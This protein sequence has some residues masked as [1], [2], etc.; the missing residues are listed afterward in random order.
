MPTFNRYNRHPL[1]VRVVSFVLIIAFVFQDVVW[2]APDLSPKRSPHSSTLAPELFTK[3]EGSGARAYLK[4]VESIIEEGSIPRNLLSLAAVKAA[5]LKHRNEPWFLANVSFTESPGQILV[6]VSSGYALRYFDPTALTVDEAEKYEAQAERRAGMAASEPLGKRLRKQLLNVKLLPPGSRPAMQRIK[7]TVVASE[8]LAAVS[9]RRVASAIRKLQRAKRGNLNLVLTRGNTMIA[10]LRELARKKGIDWSRVNILQLVEYEDMPPLS[11]FSFRSFL[12]EYFLDHL[13]ADNRVKGVNIYNIATM[14]PETYASE[15]RSRL[16]PDI[17]VIGLGLNDHIGFNEPGSPFDSVTRRV[18]LTE[19]TVRS[20]ISDN[21]VLAI[22]LQSHR[23]PRAYTMGMAEIASAGRIF[24]LASGGRKRAAV[25]QALRG[26]VTT[27]VP[28]SMLQTVASRT[29]VILDEEA[30]SGLENVDGVDGRRRSPDRIAGLEELFAAAGFRIDMDARSKTAFLK[31][32]AGRYLDEVADID[33]LAGILAGFNARDKAIAAGQE[34]RFERVLQNRILDYFLNHLVEEIRKV[35]PNSTQDGRH[36]KETFGLFR[37]FSRIF[38]MPYIR[39]RTE[40]RKELLTLFLLMHIRPEGS[41]VGSSVRSDVATE[42]MLEEIFLNR[43]PE[44]SEF[45]IEAVIALCAEEGRLGEYFRENLYPLLRSSEGLPRFAMGLINAFIN[46]E[47]ESAHMPHI[48]DKDRFFTAAAQILKDLVSDDLKSGQ[49]YFTRKL[50][51]YSYALIANSASSRLP[52]TCALAREAEEMLIEQRSRESETRYG[53]S[54][55]RALG[56]AHFVWE[57]TVDPLQRLGARPG[58]IAFLGGF[59]ELLYSGLLVSGLSVVLSGSF[60]ISPV[61]G[62]IAGTALSYFAFRDQHLYE[63][64]YYDAAEGML[65]TR[66]ATNDDIR[67]IALLNIT[68]RSL[69][70]VPLL[71]SAG[72]GV[73]VVALAAVTLYHALWNLAQMRHGKAMALEAGRLDDRTIDEITPIRGSPYA[74]G[75]TDYAELLKPALGQGGFE[76]LLKSSGVYVDAGCG[77]GRAPVEAALRYKKIRAYGVDIEEYDG[78]R[79]AAA[80]DNP[81][82]WLL[83]AV[84]RQTAR[85]SRRY[86]FIKSNISNVEL[87]ERPDLITSFFVFEKVVDP[88]GSFKNLYDQLAPG[89]TMLFTVVRPKG[90]AGTAYETVAADLL[91]ASGD[92]EVSMIPLPWRGAGNVE[93]KLVRIDKITDRQF[94]PHLVLKDSVRQEVSAG[95]HIFYVTSPSYGEPGPTDMAASAGKKL[96][97]EDPLT[98]VILHDLKNKFQIMAYCDIIM[99]NAEGLQGA[100]INEDLAPVQAWVDLAEQ[101]QVATLA[102]L[103]GEGTLDDTIATLQD[104]FTGLTLYTQQIRDRLETGGYSWNPHA[105][106]GAQIITSQST[107]NL[108]PLLQSAASWL[109]RAMN[110]VD[111][112]AVI[113]ES[114]A[115][116]RHMECAP[117]DLIIEIGVTDD[118][119]RAKGLFTYKMI[120]RMAVEELLRNALKY[121][122]SSK[123]SVNASLVG[124]GEIRVEVVD[125]GAGM[126]V[127]AR[128]KLFSPGY[129]TASDSRKGSGYGLSSLRSAIESVGG[130]IAVESELGKGSTFAFRLPVN[131]PLDVVERPR[132]TSPVIVAVSGLKGSGRRVMSQWL[133][134]KLGLRYVNVGFLVRVVMHEMLKARREGRR[135]DL[136]DEHAVVDFIREFLSSGRIDCTGPAITLDGLDT[137]EPD[138]ADGLAIR[139]RIKAEI[140]MDEENTQAMHGVFVFPGAKQALN[141]YLGSVARTIKDGGQYNGIV[142]RVTDPVPMKGIINIM[143]DAPVGVRALRSKVEVDAIESLD[144]FTGKQDLAKL[145]PDIHPIDTTVITRRT[146]E[147]AL[148]TVIWKLPSSEDREAWLAHLAKADTVVVYKTE[149]VSAVDFLKN[150]NYREV[151][152]QRVILRGAG[153]ERVFSLLGS[154]GQSSHLNLA[155]DEMSGDLYSIK[156]L[157]SEEDEDR[158]SSI[159]NVMDMTAGHEGI[160]QARIMS[161]GAN[162]WSGLEDAQAVVYPYVRGPDLQHYLGRFKTTP[163]PAY[164][165]ELFDI[166]LKVMDI[167]VFL[168]EKGVPGVWDINSGNIIITPEGRPVLIDYTEMKT[169]PVASAEFLLYESFDGARRTDIGVDGILPT[170]QFAADPAANQAIVERLTGIHRMVKDRRFTSIRQ[171]RDELMAV[172]QMIGSAAASSKAAVVMTGGGPTDMTLTSRHEITPDS[173]QRG[174]TTNPFILTHID[175]GRAFD[176][177]EWAGKVTR[178]RRDAAQPRAPPPEPDFVSNGVFAKMR[179]ARDRGLMARLVSKPNFDNL[180]ASEKEQLIEIA[181]RVPISVILG[182]A[183][184]GSRREGKEDPEDVYAHIRVAKET[185]AHGLGPTIWLGERLLEMMPREKLAQMLVEESQHLLKKP[186][187]LPSGRWINQDGKIDRRR[188]E[189]PLSEANRNVIE[190]DQSLVDYLMTLSAVAA[191]EPLTDT[192][193][194]ERH[195]PASADSSLRMEQ[196]HAPHEELLGFDVGAG[197]FIVPDSLFEA[198][199][200]A[201]LFPPADSVYHATKAERPFTVHQYDLML[202]LLNRIDPGLHMRLARLPDGGFARFNSVF[203]TPGHTIIP[204]GEALEAERLYAILRHER[205]SFLIDAMSSDKRRSLKTLYEKIS[206]DRDL[207]LTICGIL[208]GQDPVSE[209]LLVHDEEAWVKF[210][211]WITYPLFHDPV[212]NARVRRFAGQIISASLHSR[213]MASEVETARQ[214]IIALQNQAEK[215]AAIRF[216][217]ASDALSA[218]RADRPTNMAADRTR[219]DSVDTETDQGDH[220]LPKQGSAIRRVLFI[221]YHSRSNGKYEQDILSVFPGAA[222]LGVKTPGEALQ[223]LRRYGNSIGLVVTNLHFTTVDEFHEMGEGAQREFSAM[224]VLDEMARLRLSCPVV[225][226]TYSR[227]LSVLFWRWRLWQEYRKALSVSVIRRPTQ[228][229]FRRA[230]EAARASGARRGTG[231]GALQSGPTDM[232]SSPEKPSAVA[233]PRSRIREDARMR[234][235]YKDYFEFVFESNLKLFVMLGERMKAK[236]LGDLAAQEKAKADVTEYLV[237]LHTALT[238]FEER[239]KGFPQD[240]AMAAIHRF[241]VSKI[242]MA[243]EFINKNNEPAALATIA[244]VINAVSKA[245]QEA[246]KRSFDGLRRSVKVYEKDHKIVMWRHGYV[247]T[248]D[249][250]KTLLPQYIK[251]VFD[252]R[253]QAGRSLDEQEDGNADER[254]TITDLIAELMRDAA[255]AGRSPEALT[256]ASVDRALEALSGRRDVEEKR[257][258]RIVLTTCKALIEMGETKSLRYLLPLAA[259]YLALRIDHIG[260]ILENLKTG[261]VEPFRRIVSKKNER[262]I[263]RVAAIQDDLNKRKFTDALK[264]SHILRSI[265]QPYL[266]EP[267]LADLLSMVWPAINAVKEL[268]DGKI[269]AADTKKANFWLRLIRTKL[270]HSQLAGEFMVQFRGEYMRRRLTGQA[271]FL[272]QDTFVDVFE[273]FVKAKQLIRGSPE[274]PAVFASPQE[275][276]AF[277]IL[278][279]L[280]AFIPIDIEN[281]EKHSERIPNPLFK[282]VDTLRLLVE[283]DDIARILTIK[284][285]RDLTETLTA[286]AAMKERGAIRRLDQKERT[287]LI[288]AIAKDYGLDEPQ[289]FELARA[290]SITRDH[291]HMAYIDRAGQ[292]PTDMAF[293]DPAGSREPFVC[294]QCGANVT[295]LQGGFRDHCPVCLHSLHLD[296]DPGDRASGCGAIMEPVALEQN[297]K[298]GWVITYRCTA[299]GRERKNKAAPDDSMDAL[300]LISDP[301]RAIG[302]RPTDMAGRGTGRGVLGPE[303]DLGRARWLYGKRVALPVS[304]SEEHDA[305]VDWLKR[306]QRE[307][308]VKKDT[309]I[310]NFDTH[311]DAIEELFEELNPGSWMRWLK[312]QGMSTGRRVWV[313]SGAQAPYDRSTREEERYAY[314]KNIYSS[315][316]AM[317]KQVSGPAIVTIDYDYIAPEHGGEITPKAIKEKVRRIVAALFEKGIRPVAIHFAYSEE[318]LFEPAPTGLGIPRDPTRQVI[319]GAVYE[320]FGE[321][322]YLF[323]AVRRESGSKPTDMSSSSARSGEQVPPKIDTAALERDGY[324]A[325]IEHLYGLI[326]L[327]GLDAY[328]RSVYLQDDVGIRTR[329]DEL[330]GATRELMANRMHAGR[331]EGVEMKLFSKLTRD[332]SGNYGLDIVVVDNGKGL[333]IDPVVAVEGENATTDEGYGSRGLPFVR[334]VIMGGGNGRIEIETR[335]RRYAWIDNYFGP[336]ISII[337]PAAGTRI[338]LVKTYPDIAFN[339]RAAARDAELKGLNALHALFARGILADATDGTRILLSENI[340]INGGG[341]AQVL[342]QIRI[343]LA[344]AL[345]SGAIAILSPEEIRRMAINKDVTKDKMVIVMTKEDMEDK[346]VWRGTNKETSLRSSVLVLGD[347]L[348]GKNY[349]YLE[350]VIGLARAVMAKNDQAVKEYY[351]LISG[352]AIDDQI[353]QLLKDDNQNNLAFA[354]KAVLKF[355]PVSAIDGAE[356]EKARLAMESALISA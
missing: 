163:L 344:S 9:A 83:F 37:Q 139:D 206:T 300:I 75:I 109:D 122:K 123:I 26:P 318:Y 102:Y 327:L 99:M 11:V 54:N 27:E 273:S 101:M 10:F 291:L 81:A 229:T 338:R 133:A 323:S 140:D 152:A 230:L 200:R 215:L 32:I 345:K 124:G 108:L 68:V 293:L 186:K 316:D 351:R 34:G 356:F 303:D 207:V 20:D 35:S 284:R 263:R 194:L 352:V 18:D 347:R 15:L 189:S 254:D 92:A 297:G 190:H 225:I 82:L 251:T 217:V 138:P 91:R 117:D 231:S 260:R 305:I 317:A 319:T 151:A 22:K 5:L 184:I 126:G 175:E 339:E 275:I 177:D 241:A 183:L 326:D 41:A 220:D 262:F 179:S 354:L 286:L 195:A 74:H 173:F 296:N 145:Y 40:E 42:L 16:K 141:E 214:T 272:K 158:A 196:G 240:T 100:S 110:A 304:V 4:A 87:K 38:K 282:P 171:L 168:E 94:E 136:R 169:D 226:F 238:E 271:T 73:T 334:R 174:D 320:A 239:I 287:R 203:T 172:R 90:G 135:I 112:E 197:V 315:I 164:A 25:R 131:A 307:G 268:S 21:P 257:L 30:A 216:A 332:D 243:E 59:E 114:I 324:A 322:G 46:A 97:I 154:F 281:P 137:T 302:Y 162:A 208:D 235:V 187:R 144:R 113:R 328:K 167:F 89:G 312:D 153:E 149:I 76:G 36:V 118:L 277:Q 267:E 43:D 85:E 242:A 353:L 182:H 67:T 161:A 278:C 310:I 276:R 156:K 250:A 213:G 181:M 234:S 134:A 120:L 341:D 185:S 218:R 12:Q 77:I 28:A 8:D 295:P 48:G 13:P 88:L 270:E 192:T 308:L 1:I 24:L 33:D 143:L 193:I 350:G 306:L 93:L 227:P 63:V 313:K 44:I 104:G 14:G 202:S 280:A 31:Q 249:T 288:R 233:T 290:F 266:G 355:K 95:D 62:A 255:I 337:G 159:P 157:M 96:A 150:R 127:V 178:I 279:Y 29:T 205:F 330:R 331:A 342:D 221:D 265:L 86:R 111:I 228:A 224:K 256:A 57:R 329:G 274:V 55:G 237:S 246:I 244:G 47:S 264:G 219:L 245:R 130:S 232:A 199:A 51:E 78:G 45:A 98:R 79:L 188:G 3:K 119:K 147:K 115:T 70:L 66:L 289:R 311:P 210:W 301:A 61:I 259:E 160:Y 132:L 335:G 283:V 298:K 17:A 248:D 211:T 7:P 236:R 58:L 106:E 53:L 258:A 325:G 121:G 2:A 198:A 321:A 212:V 146:A 23:R 125:R 19:E 72:I 223:A 285:L 309:T 80:C 65:K 269:A 129:T 180:R 6:S 346:R 142:L 333:Q 348:S 84:A 52:L 349:L 222:V 155:L 103:R 191:V 292:K 209:S 340:F 204:A 343:A 170:L 148:R 261:R 247:R 336:A 128:E 116:A 50:V 69:Y 105:W 64:L 166:I 252:L 39:A 165:G 60:G 253:W 71:I 176:V 56:L 201:F 49:H 107:S 294:A 314:G 299:C